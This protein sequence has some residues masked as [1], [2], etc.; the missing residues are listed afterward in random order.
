VADREPPPFGPQRAYLVPGESASEAEAAAFQVFLEQFSKRSEQD[1]FSA[2]LDFLGRHPRGAW[3]SPLR[4]CLAEEFYNTGW[5]SRA[6][7][8]QDS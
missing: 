3:A 2:A 4:L 8:T 6:I 1:D 7:E 5:Y